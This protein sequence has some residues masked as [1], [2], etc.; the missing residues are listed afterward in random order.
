MPE[1]TRKMVKVVL[2]E[3]LQLRDERDR[4]AHAQF[5]LQFEPGK[6]ISKDSAGLIYKSWKNLKEHESTSLTRDTL[7]HI[8][9]RI[10]A[11]Y[12]RL[13]D[14]AL[15]GELRAQQPRQA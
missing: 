6:G 9:E 5:S 4:I 7:G 1:A 13:H 10:H 11:L 12:W 14:L 2:D 3:A 8:F 15:D